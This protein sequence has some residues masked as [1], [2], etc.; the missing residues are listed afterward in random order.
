MTNV[1]ILYEDAHI[2][3]CVKPPGMASQ[4]ER[5]SSMDLASWLKNHM[6]VQKPGSVPYI[7][8]VHRLDRPAGERRD[9]LCEKS[10][11]GC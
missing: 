11:G 10:K 5:S 2:I 3:V 9:G 1:K 8:V 7:G 4:P 6:A